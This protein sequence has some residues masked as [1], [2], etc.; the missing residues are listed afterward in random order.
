MWVSMHKRN[1]DS[2]WLYWWRVSMYKRNHIENDVVMVAT[3][4]QMN[5]TWSMAIFKELLTNLRSYLWLWGNNESEMSHIDSKV[6]WWVILITSGK[7]KGDA[8]F[9][10]PPIWSEFLMGGSRDPRTIESVRILKRGCKD[11]RTAQ[12]VQILKGERWEPRT[13]ELVRIFRGECRDPR[14]AQSVQILKGER[15]DP[16]TAELVRIFRGECRDP[17]TIE[18][19]RILKTECKGSTDGRIGPNFKKGERWDPRT[20]DLVRFL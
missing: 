7:L 1:Y 11:P 16:R 2:F 3:E 10:G 20:A 18:S 15:W 9:H 19:V 5:F 13:A 8:G 4:S 12:S 17:R 14:T 6:R